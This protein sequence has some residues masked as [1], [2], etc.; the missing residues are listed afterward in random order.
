MTHLPLVRKS[1]LALAAV[2]ALVGARPSVAASPRVLVTLTMTDKVRIGDVFIPDGVKDY[3]RRSVGAQLMILNDNTFVIS[4]GGL[5]TIAGRCFFHQNQSNGQ[6]GF[7]LWAK[8]DQ[9]D[10]NGLLAQAPDGSGQWASVYWVQ[11][12]APRTDGGTSPKRSGLT[13][14]SMLMAQLL[15]PASSAPGGVGGPGRVKR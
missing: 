13:P 8:T 5:P 4:G 2:A 6:A 14:A 9:V 3:L 15:T 12:N 7:T 1:V 11:V 10:L